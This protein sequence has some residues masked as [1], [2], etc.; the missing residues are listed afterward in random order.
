MCLGS[1]YLGSSVL[2]IPGYVSF[3]RFE[4]FSAIVSSNTFLIPFPFSSPSK[5]LLFTGWQASQLHSVTA[6][7]SAG[8]SLPC[9]SASQH[10]YTSLKQSSGHSSSLSVPVDLPGSERRSQK[11][12]TSPLP[13]FL[14]RGAGP[15][16]FFFF[17]F[18][19]YLVTGGSSLKLFVAPA[20]IWYFVIL[21]NVDL[22]LM[23][24]GG[25]GGAWDT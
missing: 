17:F 2:P 9:L 5:T 24:C 16:W 15:S 4:K 25:W 10:P 23:C 18:S 7:T 3:F 8:L 1:S 12:G 13:Q 21:V 19:Y 22:F 11:E 20:F 6:A 14:P